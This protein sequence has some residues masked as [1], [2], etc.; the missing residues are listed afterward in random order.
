L[1]KIS[2]AVAIFTI[3][4]RQNRGRALTLLL[5]MLGVAIAESFSLALI[6]PLLTFI[7][8]GE[9]QSSVN[10]LSKYINRNDVAMSALTFLVGFYFLNLLKYF[11]LAYYAWLQSRFI[12]TIQ[13]DLSTKL[14]EKYLVE[15]YSFHLQNSSAALVRNITV[16]V[17]HFIGGTLIPGMVL[18][19]ETLVVFGIL[20]ILVSIQPIATLSSALLLG[21]SGFILLSFFKERSVRW[22]VQRQTHETEKIT[23]MQQGLQGIKEV[24][25][26]GVEKLFINKFRRALSISAEMGSYQNFIQ[27]LPRLF[28][29]L[30][31]LS[32]I[33]VFVGY[34]LTEKN[35][36]AFILPVMGLF[37]AAAFRLIPSANRILASIQSLRYTEPVIAVLEKE[38]TT[39]NGLSNL[40]VGVPIHFQESLDIKDMSFRFQSNDQDVLKKINLKINRGDIV[41]ITGASGAGKTTLLNIILGLLP[42]TQGEVTVDGVDIAT[43]LSEWHQLIGYVPQE[44]FL[45]EGT[46]AQNILLERDVVINTSSLNQLL[47][48][49]QLKKFVSSLPMGVDASLDAFGIN[50]SG[51]QKQRLSLA[52]ALYRDPKILI[53]DEITSSL[54]QD[55]ELSLIEELSKLKQKFTI[56]VISHRPAILGL[57]NKIYE[58]KNNGLFQIETQS[59]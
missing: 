16:E 1:I 50:I 47:E 36:V 33:V 58:I 53:L 28:V 26:F 55:T 57:C 37:M 25:V 34:L 10:F 15:N 38:L 20:V 6:A 8:G 56:V 17:D 45:I 7:S 29:E 42:P 24:K 21:G 48:L 22:G 46:I 13:V 19:T 49:V 30:I 40:P 23:W 5:V 32:A 3:I 27:G 59:A 41:G 54:D 11:F 4:G 9:S 51:G 35:S 12:A 44:T 43:N 39:D 2:N 52:R 31:V 14:F 18:I